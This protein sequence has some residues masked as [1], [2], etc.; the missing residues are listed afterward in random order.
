MDEETKKQ[1]AAMRA[2]IDALKAHIEKVETDVCRYIDQHGAHHRLVNRQAFE[3]YAET[4]PDLDA[5]LLAGK[6]TEQ[7]F[8]ELDAGRRE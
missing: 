8:K 6:T 3:A 4:H 1:F 2:E 5:A 7:Y